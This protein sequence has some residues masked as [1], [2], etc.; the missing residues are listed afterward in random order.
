MQNWRLCYLPFTNEPMKFPRG[1]TA[2]KQSTS[3]VLIITHTQFQKQS[4]KLK[5]EIKLL[6]N[7]VCCQKPG[8]L[9]CLSPEKSAFISVTMA[10]LFSWCFIILQSMR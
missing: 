9:M 4:G 7:M 1:R 8:F 6:H 5:K 10:V 2:C 3:T